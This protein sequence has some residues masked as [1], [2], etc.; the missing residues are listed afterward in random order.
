LTI[1]WDSVGGDHYR[2]GEIKMS[3]DSDTQ[4]GTEK[5]GKVAQDW[6][7]DAFAS[8]LAAGAEAVRDWEK[9][10]DAPRGTVAMALGT[11]LG[12]VTVAAFTKAWPKLKT[13]VVGVGYLVGGYTLYQL[14]R[15]AARD[16]CLDEEVTKLTIPP[17]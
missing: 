2:K 17:A 14:V 8:K 15:A 9:S 3:H 5:V 4:Q 12:T 16:R 10:L 11:I 7:R 13:P 6:S 1:T